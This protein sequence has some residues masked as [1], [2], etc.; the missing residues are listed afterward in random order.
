MDRVQL[1]KD[2]KETKERLR[3]LKRVNVALKR[4]EEIEAELN[5]AKLELI[6]ATAKTFDTGTV[7]PAPF[8]PQ[9][10]MPIPSIPSVWQHPHS[11][12]VFGTNM[13]GPIISQ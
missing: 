3:R 13:D 1:S 10:N 2:I 5:D 8:L 9:P 11:P 6:T 7:I 12:S 4:V